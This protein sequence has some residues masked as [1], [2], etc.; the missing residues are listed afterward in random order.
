[1]SYNRH[2]KYTITA[3]R[4]SASEQQMAEKQIRRT[5]M[6]TQEDLEILI[7]EMLEERG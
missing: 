4:Y 3:L 7:N 6:L 5:T 1:M 2:F